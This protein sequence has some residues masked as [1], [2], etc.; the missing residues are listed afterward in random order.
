MASCAGNKKAEC[1]EA[2]DMC[3]D[4]KKEEE[5][6]HV[7]S[8]A[9]DNMN[10][11][12]IKITSFTVRSST[13]RLCRTSKEN[14]GVACADEEVEMTDMKEGKDMVTLLDLLDECDRAGVFIGDK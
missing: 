11:P 7:Q 3:V 8:V 2:W 4:L 12:D 14:C 1:N 10:M 6:V 5:W 13:E 9:D